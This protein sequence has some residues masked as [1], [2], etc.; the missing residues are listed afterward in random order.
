M[1]TR[2]TTKKAK[3][4]KK[5]ATKK[6]KTRTATK[7]ARAQNSAKTARGKPF[8]KGNEF[9]WRKGQPSPNPGGRPKTKIFSIAAREWLAGPNGE[10]P[11]LTNAEVAVSRCGAAA[12]DGDIAALRELLDR[13]EGRPRQ[14]VEISTD[15]RMRQIIEKALPML[16]A[17]GL[18]E[19]EAKRY[20]AEFVPEVSTW[21]N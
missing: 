18:S 1:A 10:Y 21:I 2:K 14:S 9:A 16:T 11:D 20:L 15:D 17:T 8:E 5:P 7:K 6:A 3:P 13:A 19:D 12:L 4:A